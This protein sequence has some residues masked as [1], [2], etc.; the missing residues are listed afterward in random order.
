M[1]EPARMYRGSEKAIIEALASSKVDV[2]DI[3]VR[4]RAGR[5][6]KAIVRYLRSAIEE[7]LL[8]PGDRVP[9]ERQLIQRFG[10][11]RTTVRKALHQLEELGL[12]TRIQGSGTFV[13]LG[14]STREWAFGSG[15]MSVSPSDILEAR[16]AI[17]PGFT[18]LV[19]ARA[20]EEDFKTM[21]AW[22]DEAG[23]AS[24]QL[25]FRQSTYAFHME[26]ARATRNPLIVKIF[27]MVVQ[28]RSEAGWHKL[29]PMNKSRQ[30]QQCLTRS[31]QAIL[32]A[33][34]DRDA[35]RARKLLYEHLGRLVLQV[36][37]LVQGPN[38]T[39]RGDP[40]A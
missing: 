4:E 34:R 38:I 6:T 16:L 15:Y 11:S 8:E 30:E 21:G 40:M 20:T 37:G 36:V 29:E 9:A 31:N 12:L 39:S 27:E 14:L 1:V 2:P 22:L 13:S 33:L 18:E 5:V 35:V 32:G 24:D 7:G 19:V 28:A 17:Q 23:R 3:T 25:R 10:T 26:I